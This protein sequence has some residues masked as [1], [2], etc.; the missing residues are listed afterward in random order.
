MPTNPLNPDG[1]GITNATSVNVNLTT[2]GLAKARI[3]AMMNNLAESLGL[4]E[5]VPDGAA[6]PCEIMIPKAGATGKYLRCQVSDHPNI[7]ATAGPLNGAGSQRV[8]RFTVQQA[9]VVGTAG[10]IDADYLVPYANLLN[11]N[12]T[13]FPVVNLL[14]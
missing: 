12:S 5:T 7:T 14:A 9:G 8:F 2:L 10:A 11:I 4:G 3:F 6:E 13:A 1:S